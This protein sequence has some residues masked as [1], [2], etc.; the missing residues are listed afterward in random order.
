MLASES[1]N[2]PY[3]AAE[4]A[5]LVVFAIAA[6]GWFGTKRR[7]WLVYAAVSFYVLAGTFAWIS[8]FHLIQRIP[9]VSY[10]NINPIVNVA[11]GV[12][13][14]C[15]MRFRPVW[16]FLLVVYVFFQ[17][18]QAFSFLYWC[19]LSRSTQRHRRTPLMV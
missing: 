7:L 15:V 8:Q 9:S 19:V 17:L 18:L 14:L 16:T 3:V 10:S 1:P 11:F 6:W 2:G 13:L 12:G 4:L 5:G